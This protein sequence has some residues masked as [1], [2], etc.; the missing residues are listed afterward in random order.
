M[1]E[2]ELLVP[3]ALNV[4]VVT[5]NLPSRTFVTDVVEAGKTRARDV[6]DT[7]VG[8]Q[9]VLLPPHKYAILVTKV[10]LE[11]ILVEDVYVRVEGGEQLP[12]LAVNMLIRIPF[13]RQKVMLGTND[14]CFKKRRELWIVFSESINVK[15]AAERGFFQVDMLNV[16]PN[17]ITVC[18]TRLISFKLGTWI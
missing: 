10:V 13:S 6:I 2:L 17:V 12:V 7:M 3:F 9:K 16:Y 15:I 1:C 11:A 4:I 14:L 8:D 5:R 18:P